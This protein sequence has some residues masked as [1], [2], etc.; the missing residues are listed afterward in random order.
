[1][2]I[3]VGDLSFQPQRIFCIGRNYAAHVRE[4]SNALPATPVVFMKPPQC[5]VAAG[6]DVPVPTDNGE[7]HQEAE[8]VL[9]VGAEGRPQRTQQA[10]DHVAGVSLGL[11]L[12]L[13]SLQSELKQQGLPWERAKAFEAS[14]PIG[15]FV[16]ASA[17]GERDRIIFECRVDGSLRQRGDTSLML[18]PV[19]RLLV[20]LAR[21]WT[22][23]P[24]DLV[25]TGT[26]AGVGPV[27][28]GDR[29]E[30]TS[31]A[32]GSFAWTLVEA[33]GTG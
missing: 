20:E 4:L 5:L 30:L 10:W 19:P 23:L 17:L 16:P 15:E 2:K 29:I 21:T 13:R 26:P 14:A 27:S 25:F 7:L 24:G 32:I 18:F 8:L 12:T 22:L 1:V 33:T 31:D 6:I 28:V 3:A 9:V 11:D